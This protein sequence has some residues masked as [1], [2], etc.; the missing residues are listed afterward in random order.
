MCI[1]RHREGQFATAK[2]LRCNKKLSKQ[3]RILKLCKKVRNRATREG[4]KE[5]KNTRI[6]YVD[7]IQKEF[8]KY[9]YKTEK[10]YELANKDKDTKT[11]NVLDWKA[12]C[13]IRKRKSGR[14]LPSKADGLWAY[15]KRM[16]GRGPLTTKEH[17]LNV[18]HK[19]ELIN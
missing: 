10:W 8:N 11:Y 18:G 7:A 2:F 6:N 1:P 3:R 15:A 13:L 12:W 19:E 14:L 5:R 16:E 9:N 17:Q 4:E